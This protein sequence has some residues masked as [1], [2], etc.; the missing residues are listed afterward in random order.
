M[1]SPNGGIIGVINPTSFGKCT[2]TTKTSSG[3]LTTQPGTRLAQTL[4]VA[5]GG[6]SYGVRGPGAG[7]GGFRCL[8][9]VP[10]SGNTTYP[11]VVGAG[12]ATACAPG[13][14]SSAFGNSST[15]GGRSNS[16]PGGS[17]SGGFASLVKM[18]LLLHQ[19][20][21][22]QEPMQVEEVEQ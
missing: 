21:L 8:S 3:D 18:F 7:A 14:N 22:I 10:V 20:Y 19:V 16:I 5:G 11:I 4:I 2:V 13:N 9:S 6:G 15:G 12:G 17:G 1:G